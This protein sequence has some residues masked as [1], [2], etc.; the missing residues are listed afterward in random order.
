MFAKS[1]GLKALIAAMCLTGF[2]SAFS[3]AQENPTPA[4]GRSREVVAL[5]ID[6]DFLIP[7]STDR[8]FTGGF[9]LTYSGDD[10]LDTWG[11]FDDF[12]GTVDQLFDLGKHGYVSYIPSIEAGSYG[13]TPEDIKSE[14]PI[15]DDR[16]YASLVYLSATRAYISKDG[17]SAWTSALTIGA[18]GLGVFGSIQNSIHDLVGSKQAQGWGHQ[19][20][21]GGEPTLRYQ[22]AY[23]NYWHSSPH[24]AQYKTT[25]FSSLGYLTEVGA[26]IST[27][28]G[29]ITSPDYRFNPELIAYGERLNEVVATPSG[30]EN[31][32]WGGVAIKARLYN[33]FLQGQFIDSEYSLKSSKLRPLIAETWVGYTRNLGPYYKLSYVIR[34]HTSE[35]R[36][37]KGDRSIIWGGLTLSRWF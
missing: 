34:A 9:A 2:N 16:P 33:A 25:L 15:R 35:I 37:G 31:Y 18:L 29:K 32:F 21:D 19:I 7:S 5:S 14:K 11:R 6:N 23:H 30:S 20:S 36:N 17:D 12:L 1:W 24:S 26:A 27:R 22:L 10:V 13:F 28:Q 3:L 8:D 4:V